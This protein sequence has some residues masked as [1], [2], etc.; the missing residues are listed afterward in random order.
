MR[1]RFKKIA[2]AVGGSHYPSVAGERF[3]QALEMVIQESVQ[4][5]KDINSDFEAE[6]LEEYWGNE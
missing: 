3:E 4:Y 1:E 6:Q 2:L 5:L